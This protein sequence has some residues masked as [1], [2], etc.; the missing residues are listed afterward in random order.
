MWVNHS[1]HIFPP[2]WPLFLIVFIYFG[3]AACRIL[4]LQPGTETWALG[5]GSEEH[6]LTGNCLG[7]S[8]VMQWLRLCASTTG[9]TDSIPGGGAKI[10]HAAWLGHR[11]K[12]WIFVFLL[13]SCNNSSHTLKESNSFLN[14]KF[15]NFGSCFVGY[16][17]GASQVALIFKNLPANA[18]DI[19]DVGWIPGS[20]RSPGE[21]N[22]NPL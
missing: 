11:K 12:N 18:G 19:R 8:L 10:R 13:L 15:S 9:G 16:T 22:S 4:G 21:G 20:G 1:V 14:M 5:S 2:S 6:S 7:T 17:P 3:H